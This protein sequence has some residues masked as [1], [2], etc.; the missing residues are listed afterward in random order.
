MVSLPVRCSAHSV[1]PW[2][3]RRRARRAVLP[4]GCVTITRGA[5]RSPQR[6]L[7]FVRVGL[8]RDPPDPCPDGVCA[9]FS[10]AELSSRAIATLCRSSVKRI[11]ERLVQA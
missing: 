1:S 4:V 2:N 9:S 10:S 6:A 8:L 3:F 11:W 7:L 5:I